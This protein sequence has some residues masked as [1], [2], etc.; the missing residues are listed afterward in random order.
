M[1]RKPTTMTA[2]TTAA[3]THAAKCLIVQPIHGDGLA[4]LR[5]AGVEPV[6]CPDPSMA[7]VAKLVKGCEAVI[8]R[9]AGFSAE[10]FRAADK[11]KILV[12]HGAGHDAVDKVAA[13]ECGVLCCNTPGVNAQSV[14]ELALGLALASARLIPL[15]E[16]EERA[17]NTR[18]R[19]ETKT[20]ELFG[21]TALVVGF[22]HIGSGIARMLKAAL[23][24]EVLIYSPHVGDT[25]EFERVESLEEGLK[26]ADLI[27]LNTP[28]KPETRH[29]IGTESLKVVKPG[30]I[31]VNTARAGLVDE[32]A[33]LEAI[34]DGRIFAAGLDVYEDGALAGS[35]GQNP[36]VIFTPHLGGA[37]EEAMSR[38]AKASAATVLEGL[39]GKTPATAVNKLS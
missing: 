39:A 30:A 21:K 19:D 3:G 23:D 8:T 26:R 7:T 1:N 37:T 25:G 20:V 12:V 28:L 29:M 5:A 18:F 4:L 6:I 35:L 27:S 32:A 22:G 15:A 24:M 16:R 9:N 34:E 13:T 10:A 38:I 2:P 17:G 31:L 11:L 36:R 14:R 33:L